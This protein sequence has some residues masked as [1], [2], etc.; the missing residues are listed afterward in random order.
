MPNNLKR[1][2]ESGSYHFVTFSCYHRLPYLDDDLIRMTFLDRLE[3]LRQKHEFYVF[4]YVLMPEHV[5][6]LVSE[7]KRYKLAA[8]LNVLKVEVSKQAKGNRKQFWQTRYYDFN[9]VTSAKL[10][11]KLRYMHRNPVKRGLVA[12]PQDW[13]WSS[14]CHYLTGVVGRVEIESEWTWNRRERASSHP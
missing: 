13:H 2:Q 1:Y 11:E 6:L 4:G 9:V 8:A 10:V 3:W 5:H 12:E 7:P 14:I